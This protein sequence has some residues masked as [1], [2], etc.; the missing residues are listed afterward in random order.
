MVLAVGHAE[1][2]LKARTLN[3]VFRRFL[4][5]ALEVAENVES[6]GN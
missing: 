5:D 3:D 2:T 1:K 4:N 6:K